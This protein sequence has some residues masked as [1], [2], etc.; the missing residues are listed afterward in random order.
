MNRRQIGL[1]V[2]GL[3]VAYASRTG[4]AGEPE[5]APAPAPAV[6]AAPVAPTGPAPHIKFDATEVNMGEITRGV[7][8]VATFTYRN[9]GEVPLHILSVKPG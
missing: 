7:D 1:F 9:T 3:C 5:P 4:F 6:A 2:I 8:L